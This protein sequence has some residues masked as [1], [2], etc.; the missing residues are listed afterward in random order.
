MPEATRHLDAT[1]LAARRDTGAPLAT[2]PRFC[3]YRRLEFA[4]EQRLDLPGLLDRAGSASYYP[5]GGPER[6]AA[7][8][9]LR[10]LFAAESRDGMISLHYRVELHLAERR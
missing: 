1:T 7:D 10:D 8:A 4:N 3:A 2:S 9:R 5:K 6:A